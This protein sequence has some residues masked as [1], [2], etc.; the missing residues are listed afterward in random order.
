MLARYIFDPKQ[1]HLFA[2]VSPNNIEIIASCIC[3]AWHCSFCTT[4]GDR[5][6]AVCV[7]SCVIFGKCVITANMYIFVHTDVRR[8]SDEQKKVIIALKFNSLSFETRFQRKTHVIAS[9]SVHAW[10]FDYS[11]PYATNR[12]WYFH[13]ARAD[14]Y[15]ISSLDLLRWRCGLY[16]SKKCHIS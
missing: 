11:K 10:K 13:S 5:M 2:C 4:S 16:L 8:A 9:F 7:Y 14:I 1:N 3:P 15:L 12:C 6:H